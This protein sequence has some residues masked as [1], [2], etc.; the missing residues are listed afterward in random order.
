M[1]WVLAEGWL[2]IRRHG[3]I[4]SPPPGLASGWLE[5]RVGLAPEWDAVSQA[6][7]AWFRIAQ[8]CTHDGRATLGLVD[9]HRFNPEAG[10]CSG[11]WQLSGGG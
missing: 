3:R 9:W 10:W 5:L 1:I 11:N 8:G 4:F 2:W 7:R 6:S